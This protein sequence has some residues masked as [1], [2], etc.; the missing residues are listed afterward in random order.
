M[1]IS[2]VNLDK[3]EVIDID[4]KSVKLKRFISSDKTYNDLKTYLDQKSLDQFKGFNF[5]VLKT[6]YL[7]EYDPNMTDKEIIDRMS[8]LIVNQ[9]LVTKKSEL[10]SFSSVYQKLPDGNLKKSENFGLSLSAHAV[11]DI[12]DSIFE[13]FEPIDTTKFVKNFRSKI[14]DDNKEIKYQGFTFTKDFISYKK[15]KFSYDSDEVMRLI[16]SLSKLT[17]SSKISEFVKEVIDKCNTK[18]SLSR[19]SHEDKIFKPR[20]E[21]IDEFSMIISNLSRVNDDTQEFSLIEPELLN[22]TDNNLLKS[23]SEEYESILNSCS[24]IKTAF[25]LSVLMESM[26]F[27]ATKWKVREGEF[28]YSSENLKNVSYLILPSPKLTNDLTRIRYILF[29]NTLSSDIDQYSIFKN[30]IP[31]T[32]I[33]FTNVHEEDVEILS[34]RSRLFHNVYNLFFYY[35]RKGALS[36]DQLKEG[37]VSLHMFLYSLST[38]TK[39]IISIFKYLNVITFSDFSNLDNLYD[40]YFVKNKLKN[41][42]SFYFIK[43]ICDQTEFN[44]SE[45]FKVTRSDNGEFSS[46]RNL[47]SIRINLKSLWCSVSTIKD[48]I[49]LNTFYNLVE[50]KTTNSFHSNTEFI[51]TIISNNEYLKDSNERGYSLREINESMISRSSTSLFCRESLYLGVKL[52]VQDILNERHMLTTDNSTIISQFRRVVRS[53]LFDKEFFS[54]TMTD[55]VYN[56]FSS[57]FLSSRKSMKI[58]REQKKWVSQTEND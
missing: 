53:K 46:V 40:K 30:K 29:M 27:E 51:S 10:T 3:Q 55:R 12:R 24:Y 32:N 34:Y 9:D 25:R 8:D 57:T 35:F 14:N 44:M 43:K 39:K 22:L 2:L 21:E 47:D 19:N 17:R 4:G 33:R 15:M 7:E 16:S 38:P 20:I 13:T 52:L 42:L 28:L 54:S 37:F 23:I 49:E 41:T 1:C 18:R 26:L 5:S 58:K 50:K 11:V 48:L 56:R 6:N 31:N 36:E 45:I